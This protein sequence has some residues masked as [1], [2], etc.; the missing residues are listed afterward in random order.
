MF[1]CVAER[2]RTTEE[3]VTLPPAA[4]ETLPD[5]VLVVPG[6]LEAPEALV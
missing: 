1:P 5:R 6:G 3:T 2:D 4:W